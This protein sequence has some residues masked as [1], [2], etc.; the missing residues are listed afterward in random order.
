MRS[1]YPGEFTNTLGKLSRAIRD[2]PSSV[3]YVWMRLWIKHN[4][5]LLPSFKLPFDDFLD[6][7]GL[8][9]PVK[10]LD[11]ASRS[12][13]SISSNNSTNEKTRWFANAQ[14]NA[15]NWIPNPTSAPQS[16]LKSRLRVKF[17]QKETWRREAAVRNVLTRMML[18]NRL[19]I[20]NFWGVRS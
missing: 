11:S 20:T 17:L 5:L 18:Q 14:E 6:G 9:R 4:L 15:P 2:V 8:R 7:I 1:S 10:Q 13:F 16:C 3:R 12:L 19:G